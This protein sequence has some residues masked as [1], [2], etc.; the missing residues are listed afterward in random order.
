MNSTGSINK[1][2]LAA[3]GGASG[4]DSWKC[5]FGANVA[6]HV[7]TPLFVLNSKYDTWQGGAIIGINTTID[8]LT[9]SERAF[10]VDYGRQMVSDLDALPLRHGAFVS[11]C[12]AHC[13]TGKSHHQTGIPWTATTING[14]TM[15]AAFLEWY[16]ATV[17]G[18]NPPARRIERC[19]VDSCGSDVCGYKEK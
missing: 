5:F 7:E 4:G 6:K 19:D 9:K 2:C 16:K 15:A 18:M 3:N 12:Q 14:T 10:W 1:G 11:N 13:Q 8:N 17:T